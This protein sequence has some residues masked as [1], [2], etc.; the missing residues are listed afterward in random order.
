M[1]QALQLIREFG[2]PTFVC[3]WFM[4]RIEK[5]MELLLSRMQQMILIWNASHSDD[6]DVA[7]I[8]ADG[9]SPPIEGGKVP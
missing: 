4:F 5:K 6:L 3:L 7:V 2:F 8:T 1:D 9:S